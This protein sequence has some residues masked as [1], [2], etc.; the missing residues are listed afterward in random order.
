MNEFLEEEMKIME[1][2]H[3]SEQIN[4]FLETS[5]SMVEMCA[6]LAVSKA[7][8]GDQI[9]KLT[10][11]KDLLTKLVEKNFVSETNT[12]NYDDD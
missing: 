11:K 9:A 12:S 5:Q 7:E 10:K 4:A 8:Q 2:N 3:N 1:W 6:A